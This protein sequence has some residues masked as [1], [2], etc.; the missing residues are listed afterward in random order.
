[1][2]SSVFPKQELGESSVVI[3]MHVYSVRDYFLDNPIR[4]RRCA[5]RFSSLFYSCGVSFFSPI[6]LRKAV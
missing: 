5:V 6:T 3:A 4:V 1:M 2:G